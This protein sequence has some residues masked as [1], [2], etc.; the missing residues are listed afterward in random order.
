VLDR[1]TFVPEDEGI[2]FSKTS[3]NFYQSTSVPVLDPT[4]SKLH[5][6]RRDNLQS[7]M[8]LTGFGRKRA[9]YVF[10]NEQIF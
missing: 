7:Q 8:P 6:H 3:V 9:E 1:F 5:K 2:T 4:D 10:L